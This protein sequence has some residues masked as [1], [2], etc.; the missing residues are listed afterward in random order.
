MTERPLLGALTSTR[1]LA[2]LLVV[3]YHYRDPALTNAKDS[4][5]IQFLG[6]I[7]AHGFAGVSFFFVLSGF[8]LVYSYTNG[9]SLTVE[10]RVFWAARFA[11]VYP[12]YILALFL[13]IPIFLAL[14]QYDSPVGATKVVAKVGMEVA[15][16]QSWFPLGCG[17]NCPGWSLS[18][19]A[20]FYA[21]FPFIVVN[22]NK[23]STKVNVALF[24]A[25]W[26]ASIAVS[27]ISDLL[28][29]PSSGRFFFF[30][31][32]NPLL[33][34]PQFCIGVI[35]GI[36]FLRKKAELTGASMHYNT[37]GLAPLVALFILIGI[38]VTKTDLRYT[39]F[40]NGL[41]APLFAG[42]IV[43]MA[44]RQSWLTRLLGLHWFVMLGEASYAVYILQFPLAGWWSW[45]IHG[46]WKPSF[47]SP[48][49]LLAFSAVL[50]IVAITAF[51]LVER[52]TKRILVARLKPLLERKKLIA[53]E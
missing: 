34:L 49:E 53:G 52:P 23:L 26:L 7:S 32:Y 50:T 11:R 46:T 6:A 4:P 14:F 20:F 15:L 38:A 1:Y 47:I 12:L 2:A 16:L 33:H 35:A 17:V 36:I 42:L 37:A 13:S 31:A 44:L 10:A 3:L 18:A 39:Y 29:L 21:T 22:L 30:A 27:A 51:L 41:L 9:R 19:E 28:D 24:L 45:L 48:L 8:I 25:A 43:A 40:N 5:I